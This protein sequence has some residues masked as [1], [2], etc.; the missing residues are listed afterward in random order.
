MEAVDVVNRFDGAAYLMKGYPGDS[1]WSMGPKQP[2]EY[3]FVRIG[4][5]RFYRVAAHAFFRAKDDRE[6]LESIVGSSPIMLDFPLADRE[7]F[8][9]AEYAVQTNWHYCWFVQT[10]QPFRRSVRGAPSARGL[11]EYS[12]WYVTNPDEV[13]IGFVPGVGITRYRYEH[14]G[15][16]G[17]VSAELVEVV[18]R[19]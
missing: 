10:H 11:T 15:T 16:I 12:L 8:C 2:S 7:R 13:H 5:D 3:V 18:R 19:R 4:Q 1:P 9:A 14:Q 17:R 6:S